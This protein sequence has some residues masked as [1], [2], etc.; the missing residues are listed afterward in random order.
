MKKLAKIDPE[1][2][3]RLKPND[4]QRIQRAL[5]VYEIT[6]E[7][8]SSLF[9]KQQNS[10]LPYQVTKIAL[11]PS[12]RK[13]LHERIALRF[14]QMLAAGFVDE[15]K[16]LLQKYPSLTVESTA[17]RCVGYKQVLEY[18]NGEYDVNEL[19]DR[20]I[21]AT[22]QLAKRQLTWLRNMNLNRSQ[23]LIELDCLSADLNQQV[24]EK[25]KQTL[26]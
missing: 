4:M 13:M 25:I 14:E 20:G 16:A 17:M 8:M 11:I 3:A 9:A 19:K 2:A 21:F 6:G 1:T 12:D 24:L 18:L 5:E 23:D 7:T 10:V 15:V 22:R 26:F